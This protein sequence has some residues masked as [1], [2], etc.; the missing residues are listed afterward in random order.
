MEK[1]PVTPNKKNQALTFPEKMEGFLAYLREG[2]YSLA[3]AQLTRVIPKSPAEERWVSHSQGRIHFFQ[4]QLTDARAWFEKALT[5][6]GEN[7][8][9]LVD[10]GHCYQR[11]GLLKKWQQIFDRIEKIL[12]SEETLL[13]RE[14]YHY[15][16]L[17]L[18]RF[19]EELGQMAEARDL[20]LGMLANSTNKFDRQY[21]T[22]CCQLVRVLSF[23]SGDSRLSPQYFELLQT[24]DTF[25][26][27]YLELDVQHALMVAE[28]R[29]V[30]WKTAFARLKINMTRK[31]LDATQIRRLVCEFLFETMGRGISPTSFDL[32][33]NDFEFL[34]LDPYEQ[35]TLRLVH[36]IPIYQKEWNEL[37]E[38]LTPASCL[39]LIILEMIDFPNDLEN[40]LRWKEILNGLSPESAQLWRSCAPALGEDNNQQGQF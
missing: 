21:Y 17:N 9:L 23:G 38:Q 18:G 5:Q 16:L 6:S 31:D 35:A 25:P 11:L 3:E 8:V 22:I 14:S 30:G 33:L 13:S 28:I 4:N 12:V 20:Y 32:N 7:I 24:Q 19:K 40:R 2:K 37:V 34:A 10:L 29:R 36:K 26:L 39:R 15:G 1:M 27:L